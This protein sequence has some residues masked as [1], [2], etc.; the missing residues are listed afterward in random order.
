MVST[1]EP[2]SPRVRLSDQAV[3]AIEETPAQSQDY[4]LTARDAVRRPQR[5]ARF[6]L[7][8]RSAGRHS[9]PSWLSAVADQLNALV[10][11]GQN[12]DSYG[13]PPLDSRLLVS[14]VFLLDRTMGLETPA[15]AVVPLSVGGV[16]LEW[17]Q[18]GI[19]IEVEVTALHRF[20]V[21]F[22]DRVRGEEWEGIVGEDGGLLRQFLGELT[23]RAQASVER[24][25]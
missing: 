2:A 16:Q 8:F 20:L 4:T 9:A 15:P 18:Q 10:S 7:R 24:A 21:F 14:A 3:I 22:R 19:D 11:L 1:A 17:H 23:E 13:A 5:S 12:W 25:G 6:G